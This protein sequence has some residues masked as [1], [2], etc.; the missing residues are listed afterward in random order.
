MA[1]W[2]S[3][4][5]MRPS[6]RIPASVRAI[7]ALALLASLATTGSGAG[8]RL[9]RK[10]A[11]VSA[12]TATAPSLDLGFLED[13]VR[14][15]N[16]AGV[17]VG[18]SKHGSVE[19]SAYGLAD[20]EAK[21]LLAKDDVFRLASMTKTFAAV[22]VMQLV[23]RGALTLDDPVSKLLP[24]YP[25]AAAGV[26]VRQLLDHTSGLPNFTESERFA[27]L[28][29]RDLTPPELL[30]LFAQDPL[31]FPPGSRFAY[32]NAGYVLLG[33]IVERL[34]GETFGQYLAAHVVAP[35]DMTHTAMCADV[36]AA[37]SAAQGYAA[38]ASGA[39]EPAARIGLRTP[40][41]AGGLCGTAG[42][43]LRFWSAL[44]HGKLLSAASYAA[45][46]DM[47]PLADGTPRGYGLGL[48]RGSVGAHVTVGHDGGI[49]GFST[50]M[51]RDDTEDTTVV[52][53]CNTQGVSA[54]P[55]AKRVLRAALGLALA[56]VSPP[57]AQLVASATGQYVIMGAIPIVIE[58][59]PDLVVRI[60]K[61]K[62]KPLRW[63]AGRV[64]CLAEAC[65]DLKLTAFGSALL[66]EKD[67]L[68]IGAPRAS[69]A[70]HR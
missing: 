26:T 58:A 22:A 70:E 51:I 42:D 50:A 13:D 60:G 61:G 30:A 11:T 29:S 32:S 4:P 6:H 1:A 5:R 37:W 68:S 21:R 63:E 64:L 7:S 35:A 54:A 39:L 46:K 14:A 56:P 45:M 69:G 19:I 57:P 17:V 47:E 15:G 10:P 28:E 52:V 59:S 2:G 65:D 67:G 9:E 55:L 23:E 16:L 12:P 66:L 27:A 41:A 24:A 34:S 31:L 3:M 62:A 33:M 43:V 49:A 8:A 53:L 18:V 36:P 48:G 25:G 38:S 20:R 44:A 40:Y